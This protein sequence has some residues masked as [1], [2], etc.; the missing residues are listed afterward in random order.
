[1]LVLVVL[2]VVVVVTREYPA[3]LAPSGE[4]IFLA[5]WQRCSVRDSE[6]LTSLRGGR[7]SRGVIGLQGG[8]PSICRIVPICVL[9]A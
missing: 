2:T 8:S 7:I 6:H 4:S 1:M 5:K 3:R 9:R